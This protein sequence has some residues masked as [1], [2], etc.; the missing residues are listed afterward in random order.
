MTT[1]TA[2][3]Q[4]TTPTKTA[5]A[6]RRRRPGR[7]VMAGRVAVALTVLVGVWAVG[8]RDT[9]AAPVLPDTDARFSL[10]LE[11][12]ASADHDVVYAVEQR[13]RPFYRVLSFDPASG[14]VETV[15]TVEEDAIIFDVALAP[16]GDALAVGYSPDYTIE[17]SGI[18]LLDLDTGSLTDVV[19]A[20]TGIYLTDLVWAP[21]GGSVLATEVDRTGD[22]EALSAVRV[23]ART[24]TVDTLLADAVNPAQLGDDVYALPLDDDGARRTVARIGDDGDV[25]VLPA[26]TGAADLD[27]LLAD[28][29]TGTLR[30]AVLEVTEQPR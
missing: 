17:G 18:S 28:E 3:T 8:F 1:T 22:D 7:L 25:T 9:G 2:Q 29:A 13:A 14:Q 11:V 15:M 23:D 30:V 20:A 12:V 21:D 24:G 19:P 27:H 26:D 6:H 10:D 16:G 5:A 4:T